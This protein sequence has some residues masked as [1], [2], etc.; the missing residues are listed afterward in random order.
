MNAIP[1]I[2]ALATLAGVGAGSDGRAPLNEATLAAEAAR[3]YETRDPWAPRRLDESFWSDLIRAVTP[4]DRVRLLLELIGAREDATPAI[5]EAY[6]RLSALRPDLRAVARSDAFRRRDAPW[7]SPRDRA[8]RWLALA[9]DP[10]DVA[11]VDRW[12]PCAIW[13]TR[14]PAKRT[15]RTPSDICDHWADYVFSFA[16]RTPTP[17]EC[18][19]AYRSPD[20]R[21]LQLEFRGTWEPPRFRARLSLCRAAG[22]WRLVFGDEVPDHGE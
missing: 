9:C 22:G 7:R 18:G 20:G 6:P 19:E 16:G 4:P 13:E 2:L 1:I 5:G 21:L 17:Y 14:G 10:A 12:L 11:L 8:T 15:G 3:Y